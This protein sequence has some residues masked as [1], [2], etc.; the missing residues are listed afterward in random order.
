[1]VVDNQRVDV[2]RRHATDVDAADIVAGAVQQVE[3]AVL[4]GYPQPLGWFFGHLSDGFSSQLSR[5]V[6]RSIVLD[7]CRCTAIKVYTSEVGAYP[8]V[9]IVVAQ[10]GVDGVV[11]QGE[12]VGIVLSEG[13][14]M[15]VGTDDDKAALGAHPDASLTVGIYGTHYIVG[16]GRTCLVVADGSSGL[17]VAY[18]V[19]SVL[20]C[21]YMI[22]VI[23]VE[24]GDEVGVESFLGIPERH[25]GQPALALRPVGMQSL[26]PPYP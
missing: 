25:L 15:S 2:V 3:S 26:A 14:G 6:T 12:G 24:C 1:M 13:L 8:H 10:N 22:V 17:V 5:L 4:G 21:P 20:S 7:A 11:A 19:A 23:A 16:H 18:Q 9:V